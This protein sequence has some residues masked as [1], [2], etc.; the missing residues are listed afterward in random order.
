ME[1]FLYSF[2]GFIFKVK[3]QC[4][5]MKY[6]KKNNLLRFFQREHDST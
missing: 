3:H 2:V 6:L 4:M 1:I 5:V